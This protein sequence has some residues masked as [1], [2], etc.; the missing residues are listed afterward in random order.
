MKSNPDFATKKD[1][2][3]ALTSEDIAK[4][5]SSSLQ[6]VAQ[7]QTLQSLI[8]DDATF[9]EGSDAERASLAD[10]A[11]SFR[12]MAEDSTQGV[13]SFQTATARS[14]FVNA[15]TK[16]VQKDESSVVPQG[17]SFADLHAFVQRSFSEQESSKTLQR[18]ANKQLA[19]E[20]AVK[21]AADAEA[22]AHAET[23]AR[24]AAAEKLVADAEAK[25]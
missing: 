4:T 8:T 15:Y 1:A 21:D 5:V 19:A 2:A 3:P 16:L 25:E 24:E 17:V 18:I 7:V 13:H 22:A 10:V 11:S 12:K 6:F 9:V 14:D 20:K 23:K